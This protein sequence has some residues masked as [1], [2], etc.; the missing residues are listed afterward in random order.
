MMRRLLIGRSDANQNRLAVSATE[1]I[2]RDRQRNLFRS[3]KLARLFATIRPADTA[4]S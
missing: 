2:D 4:R 1:K 3:D